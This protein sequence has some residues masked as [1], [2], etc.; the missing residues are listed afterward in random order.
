MGK[1][2]HTCVYLRLCKSVNG[3]V[4]LLKKVAKY[5]C[6]EVTCSRSIC[7]TIFGTLP[8]WLPSGRLLVPFP[9]SLSISCFSPT[10]VSVAHPR[11][12]CSLLLMLLLLSNIWRSR[13]W[14]LTRS[15]AF[16][17]IW[18]AWWATVFFSNFGEF[19]VTGLWPLRDW[20][21]YEWGRWTNF[22]TR[23]I[24]CRSVWQWSQSHY[25][26]EKASMGCWKGL[27]SL[28]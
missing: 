17:M 10:T 28:L 26:R 6:S 4:L 24:R 9:S 19:A 27:M 15:S 20:T 14:Q 23:I 3:I 2:I 21:D 16:E 22:G 12:P 1:V 11:G 13:S 25:R 7:V 18:V 8:P 5:G